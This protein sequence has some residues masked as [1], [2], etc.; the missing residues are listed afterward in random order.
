MSTVEHIDS[1]LE[2]PYGKLSKRE[3]EYCLN[4]IKMKRHEVIYNTTTKLYIK[5]AKHALS[6]KLWSICSKWYIINKKI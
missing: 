4:I 5:M 1:I 3:I 6:K 2:V